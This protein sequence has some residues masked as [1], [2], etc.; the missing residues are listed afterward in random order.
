[1]AHAIMDI[2]TGTQAMRPLGVV[3][4]NPD[5]RTCAHNWGHKLDL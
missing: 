2:R 5:V 1:M 3:N 4:N